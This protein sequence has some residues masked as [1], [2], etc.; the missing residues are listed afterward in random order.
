MLG[1]V[2]GGCLGGGGGMALGAEI[3]RRIGGSIFEASSQTQSDRSKKERLSGMAKKMGSSSG[4]CL[5][6]YS[7]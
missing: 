6:L 4:T 7:R 3:G 2:S 1:G 5:S